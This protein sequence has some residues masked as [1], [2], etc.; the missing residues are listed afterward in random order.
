MALTAFVDWFQ[1][2]QVTEERGGC[3]LFTE[4]GTDD[5]F[6][7]PGS[8][9]LNE[10]TSAHADRRRHSIVE[11]QSESESPWCT[12][13]LIC[14]AARNVP[15]SSHPTVTLS[16]INDWLVDFN[17]TRSFGHRNATL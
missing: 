16:T 6:W 11:T 3:P 7:G 4:K 13:L 9:V 8:I 2:D 14:F 12:S 15:T 17:E 5:V 1:V 10:C